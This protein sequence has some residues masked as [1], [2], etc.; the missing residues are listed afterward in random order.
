MS[1]LRTFNDVFCTFISRDVICKIDLGNVSLTA[2][3][4][5]KVFS[6]L[7]GTL[8]LS[9]SRATVSGVVEK[10]N[11]LVSVKIKNTRQKL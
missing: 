9:L 11:K 8:S 3:F 4:L 10:V 1:A 6:F 7:H 2:S 5:W